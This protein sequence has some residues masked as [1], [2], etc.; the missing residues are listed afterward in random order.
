MEQIVEN[1]NYSSF[2]AIAVVAA[3][4]GLGYYLGFVRN[5]NKCFDTIRQEINDDDKMLGEWITNPP[6]GM[7]M[8]KVELLEAQLDLVKM[9]MAAHSIKMDEHRNICDYYYYNFKLRMK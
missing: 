3:L 6:E 5:E 8:T 7:T 9:N 2:I 1:K 4:G